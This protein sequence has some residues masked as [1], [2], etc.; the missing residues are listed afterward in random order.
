MPLATNPVSTDDTPAVSETTNGSFQNYQLPA[1]HP[2]SPHSR[3]RR[4]S[5]LLQDI[6]NTGVQSETRQS[7]VRAKRSMESHSHVCAPRGNSQRGGKRGGKM[8]QAIL[9]SKPAVHESGKIGD[10]YDSLGGYKERNT[11]YEILKALAIHNMATAVQK[12]N[13]NIL[14]QQIVPLTAV[15]FIQK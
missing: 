12:W 11:S 4:I 14:E 7:V 10:I 15:G 1:D 2:A 13:C 3:K 6:T 8:Q 5:A 9:V